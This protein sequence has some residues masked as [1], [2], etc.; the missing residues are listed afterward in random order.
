[1]TDEYIDDTSVEHTKKRCHICDKSLSIYNDTGQCFHHGNIHPDD[2]MEI[3][4]VPESISPAA[5]EK[6]TSDTDPNQ[7]RD[8]MIIMMVCQTLK[9]HWDD[10]ISSTR[11]AAVVHARHVI[12]YLLYKDTSLSYPS[13]GEMLGG[14]DHTTVIHGVE[15]IATANMVDEEVRALIKRLRSQY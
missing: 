14:R 6:T 5:D 7:P 4:Y 8:Q 3:I 2:R 11:K 1:M 15:A 12:M 10:I 13:I 9:V